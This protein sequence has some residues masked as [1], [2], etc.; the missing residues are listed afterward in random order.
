MKKLFLLILVTLLVGFG[1]YMVKDGSSKVKSY[2][3]GDAIF[4]QGKT[5]VMTTNT[6]KLEIFRADGAQLNRI[7]TA[8]PIRSG[9]DTFNTATFSEENGRLYVYA[10]SAN[11]LYKYDAENPSRLGLVS[12][13][14]DNSWDWIG[15]IDMVNGKL[16]TIGSKGVK[17]WNSD[18]Q[19][20][21]SYNVVN[22]TNPYNIRLSDDGRF[23]FNLTD[24]SIRIFD[25]DSRTYFR[26]IRLNNSSNKGN[27]QLSF[28]D[29]SNM[30]YVIDDNSYKRFGLDGSLYKS[31]KHDS[32]LGYDA[33]LS[34]DPAYIYLTNGTSIVKIRQADLYFDAGFENKG[35]KLVGGWAMGLKR[36]DTPEGEK[37][38]VF[39][40]TNI[41]VLDS[42]LKLQSRADAT[43][44]TV[45]TEI[46]PESLA[47]G[48]DKNRAAPMSIVSLHGQGYFANEPLDIYFADRHYTDV[49][50]SQGRFKKDLYVPTIKD[51]ITDI[52]VIG[53]RSKLSY[54]INFYIE[55]S[56]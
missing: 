44:T 4:H 42:K 3:S 36:I 19:V 12:T 39:N 20:V 5:L 1:F 56:K 53:Q 6:G 9:S 41:L 34:A 18:M 21:D 29:N 22:T 11:T 7:T 2:Y 25:R 43:E 32:K 47:L 55:Q 15:R 31:L 16:V 38:V 26:T 48:I 37:V 54:S 40:S 10:A 24:N 28:D 8:Y 52:K 50:D 13:V 49:T 27:K 14:K 45:E 30:L 17:I 46:A 23:I 51:P 33:V 35:A